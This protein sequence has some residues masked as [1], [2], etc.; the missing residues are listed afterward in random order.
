MSALHLGPFS[1]H[2]RFSAGATGEVWFGRH[3]A[4]GVAVAVKVVG[5]AWAREPRYLRAFRN[6]VRQVA[7]L[8][9]AHV[10]T[11]LDHGE[12][13]SLPG[14]S[15]LAPGSPYLVMEHAPGGSLRQ[16]LERLDWPRARA[17]LQVLLETLSH[18]HARGV[19]HR[20]LKPENV[21][22]SD[23]GDLARGLR[24]SDFGLAPPVDAGDADEGAAGG[25]PWYMAPEQIEG[26][27]ERQG[28]WTDLYA[29]GALGW[30]LLTGT[31][32]YAC[33]TA[34]ESC[35]AALSAPLP[36]FRARFPAPEGVERWLQALL[37]RD[38]RQRPRLAADALHGLT[39]LGWSGPVE[40]P[41]PWSPP[42][43]PRPLHTTYAGS[44]LHEEPEP[45]PPLA[46]GPPPLAARWQEEPS[47]ELPRVVGAGLSLAPLR[48]PAL[49]GRRSERDLLWAT[50]HEVARSRAPRV[51][52]LRG[53]QGL[54]KSSLGVW[55]CEHA[56]ERGAANALA[57]SLTPELALGETLASRS[58]EKLG[59]F[60]DYLPTPLPSATPRE[61]LV[62]TLALLRA[63]SVDRPL[64]LLLDDLA[65]CADAVALVEHL[66]DPAAEGE[67]LPLL[68][69]G[70]LDEARAA[71]QPRRAAALGGAGEGAR[72]E[73]LDLGALPEDEL[74]ALAHGGL[75][76]EPGLARQVARRSGGSPLFATQ[77]VR[78]WIR[79]GLLEAGREGFRLRD[80]ASA[81]LPD[82]LH[83]LW[84]GR[85][86]EA[87]GA[88]PGEVPWLVQGA[89]L[90][91]VVEEALWE[92]ACAAGGW[93]AERAGV[94]ALLRAGLLRALDC[95]WAFT[96]EL[97][98][99]SVARDARERGRWAEA[100]QAAASALS[101]LGDV[102]RLGAALLEAGEAEAALAPLLAGLVG[103]ID[104]SDWSAAQ[105][106]LERVERAAA[107]L[108]PEDPR[109]GEVALARIRLH[110][111]R[112]EAQE[113]DAL[114]GRVAEESRR[115]GWGLA[116]IRALRYRGMARRKLGDTQQAEALLLQAEALSERAGLTDELA[117]AR[118]HL[119]TLLRLVADAPGALQA[120]EQAV[121]GF[122]ALG[123]RFG[124]A[125]ALSELCNVHL[126]L[127]GDAA[128]A[129][130]AL[131]AARG[132]YE[133]IGRT[134]GLAFCQTSL[135]EILR[136]R[137]ELEAAARA[138]E[139]ALACFE[140]LG[141]ANAGYLHI[142]LGLLALERGQ[143]DELA[144]RAVLARKRARGSREILAYAAALD[145]ALAGLRGEQV[146]FDAALV[147]LEVLL[148][149][150]GLVASDLL[151]CAERAAREARARGMRGAE[152]AEG[153]AL[154][155]RQALAGLR[156]G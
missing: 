16:H 52:L 102:G 36:L 117:R 121:A 9:H 46:L 25:T 94:E 63:A 119:G 26:R 113:A 50:L 124:L 151:L 54:G 98:R 22:I 143:T 125:D 78:A 112:G 118:L 136:G 122:E 130:A 154:A 153:L 49:V 141:S 48:S 95:G 71:E 33:R 24:L 2:V 89:A 20:D 18:V 133:A 44:F 21:L 99:E 96:H 15:M 1:L 129:E 108:G 126:T 82:D 68:L 127:R 114:A 107:P 69:I 93:P 145:L 57:L 116:R 6:E 76:V 110:L 28:P 92:R 10:V 53:P 17:L 47:P 11:V 4:Q 38:P 150:S 128:A 149:D 100:N 29:L 19:L 109:R 66:R 135:G 147:E 120:L 14:P 152:R 137:G 86:E 13:P 62:A 39:Q 60:L 131:H 80:G 156:A 144:R 43:A 146:G 140:R 148:A 72:Q 91:R 123:D 87:L 115:R 75:G 23:V 32:P 83:A 42:G 79:A 34:R 35:A 132:H 77:L 85:V 111:E 104:R 67:G 74:L 73:T 45:A 84:R 8:S 55:L 56:V 103:R 65:Q 101:E 70:T 40:L 81:A 51:L 106:E 31:P 142:N 59:I 138:W 5:A 90:G 30:E 58:R 64:V 139:E 12:V 155:Q 27:A 3:E 134:S 61:R 97:L 105:D 41:L 7:R 88:P 37:S